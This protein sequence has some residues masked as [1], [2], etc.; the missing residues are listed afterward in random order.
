MGTHR[1]RLR[2]VSV[3][4]A[5]VLMVFVGLS[6]WL[7]NW[8]PAS[9]NPNSYRMV[10]ISLDQAIHQTGVLDTYPNLTSFGIR[11]VTPTQNSPHVSSDTVVRNTY[12]RL[13]GYWYPG[14]VQMYYAKVIGGTE[15][16]HTVWVLEDH[17]L[18]PHSYPARIT[19][20]WWNWRTWE[21]K[22]QSLLYALHVEKRQATT[23]SFYDAN[24]A[25]YL[26]ALSSENF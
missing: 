14:N 23:F 9:P 26:G 25:K 16:G 21:P 22:Y 2:N 24:T 20:S 19:S 8:K 3:G 18:F 10:K 7:W 13:N 4:V 15:N 1:R 17:S 12:S 11:L 6:V 5:T